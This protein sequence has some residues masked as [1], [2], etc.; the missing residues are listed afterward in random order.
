[1][2]E[3]TLDHE[4]EAEG[5]EQAIERIEIIKPRQRYALDNCATKPNDKRGEDQRW[6]IADAEPAQQEIASKGT[7]HIL[8]AM[9]KVDDAQKSEDN[10]KAKAQHGIERA[11]D[12]ADQQLSEQCLQRYSKNHSHSGRPYE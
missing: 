5:K 3:R 8:R 2:T 9:G 4:R 1:I 11:I 10:G 6:P 7:Q 12:E